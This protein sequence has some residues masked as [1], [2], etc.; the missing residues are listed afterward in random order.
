MDFAGSFTNEISLEQHFHV[1]ETFNADSDDV[2]VWE[3]DRIGITT[4]ISSWMEPAPS[5]HR[6][7]LDNPLENGRAACQHDT[8]AQIFSGVNVTLHDILERS[9]VDSVGLLLSGT[10]LEGVLSRNGNVRRQ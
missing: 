9:V 5:V 2:S 4:L 7:A 6:H 1:K 10:W 8:V 3:L